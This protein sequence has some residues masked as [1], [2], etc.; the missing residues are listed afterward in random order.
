MKLKVATCQFPTSANIGKNLEYILR[1]TRDAKD[2]DADVVHFPEACLSGY[3]GH[4]IASYK[5]FNWRTL[6]EATPRVLEFAN[7]LQ[8]W[9]ILGSTHRLSGVNKPHNSAYIVNDHGKLIDRY[10]KM[11]CAGDRL[12]KTGE[13]AHYSPGNHFSVFSIRGVRCGI[14]ICHEYRYPELYREY[15]R[16]GVQLIFHSYHAG[17]L[18]PKQFRAMQKQVGEQFHKL[19]HG[20]TL[21]EITMPATMQAAAASNHVWISCSNSSARES[22]WASFFVRPDGVITGRLRRNIAGVLIS[23]VNDEEEFYDSTVAWRDRAMCGIYH[24]GKLVQ[25][26]RSTERKR[27]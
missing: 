22:C 19:N 5:G 6:A 13:L 10:D 20:T 14:L 3:V 2:Q 16:K 7:E 27:L 15:K 24:S 8:I 1:Q 18:K 9:I 23:E 12:G 11:F 21:P 25:D 26:R 4:D 17:H